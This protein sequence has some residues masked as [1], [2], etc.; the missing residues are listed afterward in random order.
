MLVFLTFASM[1]F[2][3]DLTKIKKRKST[4]SCPDVQ[5]SVPLLCSR[6]N[7]PFLPLSW[8]PSCQEKAFR[9]VEMCCHYCHICLL[10]KTQRV[11]RRHQKKASRSTPDSV[12]REI[13]D[14][15]LVGSSWSL[16][17]HL[18]WGKGTRAGNLQ[19][20][21]NHTHTHTHPFQ[22]QGIAGLRSRH[23][24]SSPDPSRG[25]GHWAAA[26]ADPHC[27]PTK[28]LHG[29]AGNSQ[30]PKSHLNTKHTLQ[31]VVLFS[32]VYRL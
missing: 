14:T 11:A 7:T 2:K 20:K 24:H 23:Q 4:P 32:L 25:Q 6:K 29:K 1:V 12:W 28:E 18:C 26:E 3:R 30:L 19:Q 13:R 10:Q 15:N 27:I 16:G 22:T 8:W 9:G 5:Q 17:K 21:K 31:R